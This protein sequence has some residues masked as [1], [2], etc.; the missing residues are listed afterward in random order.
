M[1]HRE[2]ELHLS[3]WMNIYIIPALL[4]TL[5]GL[6]GITWAYIPASILGLA[7]LVVFIKAYRHD[8]CPNPYTMD[9]T[10]GR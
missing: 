7:T 3:L 9:M 8:G 2:R 1:T 5:A 4:L 6:H 10:H